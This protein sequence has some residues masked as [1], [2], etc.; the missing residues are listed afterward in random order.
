MRP[1]KHS[2][3][4][5]DHAHTK[6]VLDLSPNDI[7]TPFTRLPLEKRRAA[8]T[9]SGRV[10]KDP[11]QTDEHNDTLT[12]P[13][14]IV[15]R[16]DALDLDPKAPAQSLRSWVQEK[17][18]N[19]VTP[20]RN[21]LY[22]AAP[23]E[24]TP[25]VSP[26]RDWLVPSVK[27]ARGRE[28]APPSTEHIR[29]YLAAFYHGL[30]VRTFPRPFRWVAWDGNKVGRSR[31]AW[32]PSYVGLAVD[33]ECV[34]VR[35]RANAA[36]D[37]LFHRQLNL[38]DMLDALL[39]VVPADAYAIVLLTNHD[40]YEDDEDDFCAGRAFGQS[41]I[42][43]VSSFRYNPA[44]DDLMGGSDASHVWP[45]SHCWQYVG[46]LRNRIPRKYHPFRNEISADTP[47]AMP[48]AVKAASA[49]GVGD[50]AG[51]WLSRVC[52]T[53]SHE[54]GHCFA[55]DHC[56]YYSCI[57]QS[58]SCLEE[59]DRQ[60]PFLCPVCLPKLTSA[61]LMSK[62]GADKEAEQAY[63][64]RRYGALREFCLAWPDAAIFTGFAAWNPASVSAS[65]RLAPGWRNSRLY[66]CP[67]TGSMGF[68]ANV[69]E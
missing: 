45:A 35:C 47:G 6:L 65:G 46:W 16:N 64:L 51:L 55:L 53:A 56:V 54:L 66:R 61:V 26:M 69:L 22:V 17:D 38:G 42:A 59:D 12:F 49:C 68:L 50:E 58:T 29:D 40:T 34:G 24:I 23:P 4:L 48:A 37:G 19:P 13:S 62:P 21:V 30:E 44:I 18:R 33:D 28:L 43:V 10:P 8:A 67:V 3:L 32:T 27:G 39:E 5:S 15:I 9:P 2:A 31:K 7:Q 63:V 1:P 14:P 57:M 60:P 41:R 25:D 20:A 11:P 52:K 36:D